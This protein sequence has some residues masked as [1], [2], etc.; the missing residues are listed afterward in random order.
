MPIRVEYGTVTLTVTGLPRVFCSHSPPPPPAPAPAPAAPAAAA[1]AV[2]AAAG[3]LAVLSAPQQ[4]PRAASS[5]LALM[6]PVASAVQPMAARASARRL[7]MLR[8]SSGSE[9][10][11]ASC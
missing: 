10:G 4:L 7:S 1:A 9:I 6:W 5:V 11:R 8:P 2:A 3:V